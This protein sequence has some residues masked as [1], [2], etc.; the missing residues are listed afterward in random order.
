MAKIRK[1]LDDLSEQP[2]AREQA[3]KE[4][5]LL[6]EQANMKLDI[7]ENQLKDLFRN[8]E[9]EGQIQIVGDRMGAFAREYRVNYEDGNISDAVSSL[10]NQIM[11]IGSEK[12]QQIISKAITNALNALFTNVVISEEEKRLF[13]IV[14]EGVALVRYDIYVWRKSESDSGLFKHAESVVAITYARSVVD[15]TKVSDDELNDA[16]YRSLG[17]VSVNDIIEYKKSLIELFKLQATNVMPICFAKSQNGSN[18]NSMTVVNKKI[19]TDNVIEA[20]KFIKPLS[21]EELA[22]KLENK[23]SRDTIFAEGLLR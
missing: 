23:K 6:V 16:I 1:V 13:V 21:E 15:H 2:E 19:N 14:L 17:T 11:D 18:G 8:R 22:N 9:L 20:M 3:K 7:L 5:A 4:A 12:A 10:V